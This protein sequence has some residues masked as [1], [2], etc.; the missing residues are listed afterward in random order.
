LAI[1]PKINSERVGPR[2]YKSEQE[3][4]G[5]RRSYMAKTRVATAPPPSRGA[6]LTFQP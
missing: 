1:T 2:S 5:S 4:R 3:L 6:R